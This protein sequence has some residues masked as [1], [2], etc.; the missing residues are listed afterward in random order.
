MYIYICARQ[1]TSKT[2]IDRSFFNVQVPK[3]EK[4]QSCTHALKLLSNAEWVWAETKYDGERAQ[5]HVIMRE[6]GTSEVCIFSKSKRNSTKDRAAVHG[7][8]REALGLDEKASGPPRR[9]LE[10]KKTIILDAEMV[11][12]SGDKV[13]GN[14]L[15]F[16]LHLSLPLKALLKNCR[17]LAHPPSHSIKLIQE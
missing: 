14:F 10:F 8:I 6:D 3:S 13:T 2:S 5:I 12:F 17:I 7:I 9:K 16:M 1:T 15:P 4:G 11:A